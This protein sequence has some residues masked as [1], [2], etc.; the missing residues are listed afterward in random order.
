MA[1]VR[2]FYNKYYASSYIV[3]SAFHGDMNLEHCIKLI[4]DFETAFPDVKMV[5]EDMIAEGDK[6]TMRYS[7]Q[8]THKGSYGA[9][10]PTGKQISVKDVEIFRIVGGKVV[11]A[12]DFP[13]ALG[14][15]TQLGAIPGAG[16]KK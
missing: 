5:L 6:V 1:K 10:P 14:L 13:D 7:F 4:M 2:L 8:G 16:A 11:E 9:I 12:W 15:L 3:H